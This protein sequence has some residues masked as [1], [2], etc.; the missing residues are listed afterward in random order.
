MEQSDEA[1][2]VLVARL[3]A[4]SLEDEEAVRQLAEH[5]A[6]QCPTQSTDAPLDRQNL[7]VVNLIASHTNTR[8]KVVKLLTVC[9]Q[10]TLSEEI[11]VALSRL[12]LQCVAVSTSTNSTPQKE[13][14]FVS[15][16]L[17]KAL[18]G[19]LAALPYTCAAVAHAITTSCIADDANRDGAT[20]TITSLLTLPQVLTSTDLFWGVSMVLASLLR[21]A[22]NARLFWEHDA[23][24]SYLQNICTV[25]H[26]SETTKLNPAGAA[27]LLNLCTH[28]PARFET[29]VLSLPKKVFGAVILRYLCGT[30][31]MVKPTVSLLLLIDTQQ[32]TRNR[33]IRQVLRQITSH[34]GFHT[35]LTQLHPAHLSTTQTEASFQILKLLNHLV[36]MEPATNDN[37]SEPSMAERALG[38]VVVDRLL[39]ALCVLVQC[40][41]PCTEEDSHDDIALHHRVVIEAAV[42]LLRKLSVNRKLCHEVCANLGTEGLAHLSST[43][44][45]SGTAERSTLL[46]VQSLLWLCYEAASELVKEHLCS[47]GYVVLGE[48][49]DRGLLCAEECE[50]VVCFDFELLQE[51]THA[52]RQIQRTFRGN[53]QRRDCDGQRELRR[54]ECIT[55]LEDEQEQEADR[56]CQKEF[57][58]RNLI[59]SMHRIERQATL[60]AERI[61]TAHI[62]SARSELSQRNTIHSQT[63]L[64]RQE[65]QKRLMAKKQQDQLTSLL[66]LQAEET[67]LI[68]SEQHDLN[69][70]PPTQEIFTQ[71]TT[72]QQRAERLKQQHAKVRLYRRGL[73]LESLEATG[74]VHEQELEALE[75]SAVAHEDAFLLQLAEE[76]G[77]GDGMPGRVWWRGGIVTEEW[78]EWRCLQVNMEFTWTAYWGLLAATHIVDNEDSTYQA[79]LITKLNEAEGISSS[80]LCYEEES[81]ALSLACDSSR[82]FTE[83]VWRDTTYTMWLTFNTTRQMLQRTELGQ[84]CFAMIADFRRSEHISHM[85]QHA[86]FA[87]NTTLI[88]CAI[89]AEMDR[90]WYWGGCNGI[91]IFEDSQYAEL[92]LRFAETCSRA[93][94]SELSGVESTERSHIERLQY[95]THLAMREEAHHQLAERERTKV[96]DLFLSKETQRRTSITS[97]EEAALSALLVNVRIIAENRLLNDEKEDRKT[98]IS[99]E[100]NGFLL[101]TLT[102]RLVQCQTREVDDR[103]CFEASEVTSWGKL[104][105]FMSTQCRGLHSLMQQTSLATE[106]TVARNI[107]S[108]EMVADTT[109]LSTTALRMWSEAHTRQSMRILHE[110]ADSARSDTTSTH[111]AELNST[112]TTYLEATVSATSADL[113]RRHAKNSSILELSEQMAVEHLNAVQTSL[114]LQVSSA[115]TLALLYSMM[116]SEYEEICV[117][118]TERLVGSEECARLSLGEDL[119]AAAW[120]HLVK[121][122]EVGEHCLGQKAARDAVESAEFQ[123]RMCTEAS[124]SAYRID[125]C[126]Q[127]ASGMPI[128]QDFGY[129]SFV[130]AGFYADECYAD[131]VG[132]ML[133]LMASFCQIKYDDI[134]S[135]EGSVRLLIADL[136]LRSYNTAARETILNTELALRCVLQAEEDGVRDDAVH[137]QARHHAIVVR[138]DASIAVQKTYRMHL[139]RLAA[140]ARK[141]DTAQ[142]QRS[143]S[144]ACTEQEA[145]YC[146]QRYFEGFALIFHAK[147]RVSVMRRSREARF[148]HSTSVLLTLAASVIHYRVVSEA[149]LRVAVP[150]VHSKLLHSR[151]YIN[152]KLR[153]AAKNELRQEKLGE[154]GVWY[155]DVLAKRVRKEN[156]RIIRNAAVQRREVVRRAAVECVQRV[157]RGVF[158]R[159]RMASAVKVRR[160]QCSIMVQRYARRALSV[161]HCGQ[162]R[163]HHL[164]KLITKLHGLH[165]IQSYA[166]CIL[167]LA[168]RALLVQ[169][170]ASSTIQRFFN[171]TLARSR[172]KCVRQK[173]VCR[174]EGIVQ[175]SAAMCVQRIWR[176]VAARRRVIRQKRV[177]NHRKFE[178]W[179]A[180]CRESAQRIHALQ[181][182]RKTRGLL[183][184]Q[185]VA[186]TRQ[187]QVVQRAWRCHRSRNTL[188]QRR[189]EKHCFDLA[190]LRLAAVH[191]LQYAGRGFASRSLLYN[192]KRCHLLYQAQLHQSAILLQNVSH[193]LSGRIRLEHCHARM[194]RASIRIQCFFRGTHARQRAKTL[195]IQKAAQLRA[196]ELRCAASTIQFG[197]RAHYRRRKSAAYRLQRYFLRVLPS[198]HIAREVLLQRRR[199]A[200]LTLRKAARIEAERRIEI[201]TEQLRAHGTLRALYVSTNLSLGITPTTPPASA[202]PSPR[203]IILSPNPIAFGHLSVEE[204]VKRRVLVENAIRGLIDVVVNTRAEYKEKVNGWV[205]LE[206]GRMLQGFLRGEVDARKVVEREQVTERRSL[207]LRMRRVEKILFSHKTVSEGESPADGRPPLP[208]LRNNS[209]KRAATPE[210]SNLIGSNTNLSNIVPE[211]EFSKANVVPRVPSAGLRQRSLQCIDATG[212]FLGEERCVEIL[213]QLES[214]GETVLSLR[215]E[216]VGMGDHGA[217]ALGLLLR[218]NRSITSVSLAGNPALTDI[219]ARSIVAALKVNPVMRF[220]DTD[221]TGITKDT[222]QLLGYLL[223]SNA[224]SPAKLRSTVYRPPSGERHRE[225][226]RGLIQGVKC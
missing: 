168:Q 55:A 3:L 39:T 144:L 65:E 22:N 133:S 213:E 205:V 114:Q 25:I 158:V 200:Q 84:Q 188:L 212:R 182:G 137:L 121:G 24:L 122:H 125:L 70:L 72:L 19:S 201:T 78:N 186:M 40:K 173:E 34:E 196:L 203:D 215:M 216:R 145:A 136:N 149:V 225:R 5:F 117:A 183:W 79:L 207:R 102:A 54:R 148:E 109:T 38:E 226:S 184:Q 175:N 81:H 18:C 62:S 67:A 14:D 92:Q 104:L 161:E 190:S 154:I 219:G 10:T 139:G 118:A 59:A 208:P 221:G 1:S 119:E 199:L 206:V 134:A 26:N 41:A 83:V 100:T 224:T 180:K 162:N 32:P 163:L 103:S 28:D 157:G 120:R 33:E 152:L 220:I 11:Q 129:H 169:Q 209:A 223:T 138:H 94:D 146:R 194:Y 56:I 13:N 58:S 151:L 45:I 172:V 17:C 150:S 178:Q 16:G 128:L 191:Q 185:W 160:M 156:N 64:L 74:V 57:D 126:E 124:E 12:V 193:G 164:Q 75:A 46:L 66:A 86:T 153:L 167:S 31:E 115:Q 112:Y 214:C 6:A 107:I 192:Q 89:Q 23:V 7:A 8:R 195:R 159:E 143:L 179:E 80:A 44:P 170:A 30:P 37:S 50:Y 130:K 15:A 63:L 171:V 222:K 48:M 202:P 9:M 211:A 174:K 141:E 36:H 35:V 105:A 116:H 108:E 111:N 166:R 113:L 210:E 131:F 68:A 43:Y 140:K 87:C 69:T 189:D 47:D 85:T 101:I 90:S 147:A 27:I 60:D 71:L 218:N 42:T 181:K 110:S 99:H 155:N 29:A 177:L 165:L 204:T 217:C 88:L 4:V 61:Q 95:T 21:S 49:R 98:V 51:Q 82:S 20:D 77:R 176:G 96:R 197:Y 73:Y 97:E 93:R 127:F 123:P 53:R 91:Y 132:E 2:E 187:V 198:I 106:E 135:D 52:A 142:R 76:K